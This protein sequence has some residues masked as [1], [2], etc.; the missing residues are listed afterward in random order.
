MNERELRL[1]IMKCQKTV[2][3]ACESSARYFGEQIA[4]T[5]QCEQDS[6]I[7]KRHSFT[8]AFVQRGTTLVIT[9]PDND[10]VDRAGERRCQPLSR[11]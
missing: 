4:I 2:R 1:R 7:T 6:T 8:S 10:T 9:E 11:C 3:N 5:N